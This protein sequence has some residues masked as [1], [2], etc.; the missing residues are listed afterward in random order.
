MFKDGDTHVGVEDTDDAEEMDIGWYLFT[1][2]N[3]LTATLAA[4]I[5]TEFWQSWTWFLLLDCVWHLCLLLCDF[6]L[7]GLNNTLI[8]L[9]KDAALLFRIDN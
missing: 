3:S 2:A 5:I 6:R 7:F 9:N 8:T 4:S 1:F